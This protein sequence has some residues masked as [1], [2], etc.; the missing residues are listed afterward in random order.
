MQILDVDYTLVDEKPIIR[1]FGKTEDGK[2]VCGF[3]DQFSPYVYIDD[4]KAIDFLKGD[5]N[6]VAVKESDR[7]FIG[8]D[9]LAFKITTK[10]PAKTPDLREKLRSAG[11]KAYEAD[12]LFRY[13]FLNDFGLGGL[14]WI[15]VEGSD[16]NTNTVKADRKIRI[17]RLR[18]LTSSLTR[19]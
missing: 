12:I 11:F 3:Y 10:N 6:I 2:T 4:K 17:T 5:M 9:R 16:A 18:K 13:R 8:S 15:K 7:K 1:I 14:H 19:S